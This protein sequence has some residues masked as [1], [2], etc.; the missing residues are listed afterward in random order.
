MQADRGGFAIGALLLDGGDVGPA[1]SAASAEAA[2]S[3]NELPLAVDVAHGD[4]VQK[5][6]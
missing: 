2:V 5:T 6:V 1:E 4:G 3:C